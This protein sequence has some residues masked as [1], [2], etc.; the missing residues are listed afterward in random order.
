MGKIEIN[1]E[2]SYLRGIIKLRLRIR[3]ELFCEFVKMYKILYQLIVGQQENLA[4]IYILYDE[5]G[6]QAK[7]P[8]YGKRIP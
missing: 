3:D 1:E 2:N 6:K 8:V 5:A 7:G 4:S